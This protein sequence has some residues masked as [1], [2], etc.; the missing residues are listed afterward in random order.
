MKCPV[1][2]NAIPEQAPACLHCGFHLAKADRVFGSIPVLDPTLNDFAE[3]LSE[4]EKDRIIREV[5]KLEERF[6]QLRFAIV[7]TKLPKDAPLMAYYFWLFN[8]G[9]LVSQLESGAQ[10]RLVLL[11]LDVGQAR[12]FCMV[13]YGL[14]PFM[15]EAVLQ[16]VA[17]SAIPHLKAQE[18]AK[19]ALAALQE[20]DT[21]FA[22]VCETLPRAYG[23]LETDAENANWAGTL[24]VAY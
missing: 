23:L 22:A 7:L 9:N 6:P 17:S 21:Q 10:C 3:V 13:G 15:T 2:Q 4:K 20:I 8:R 14:E 5:E 12:A 11:G 24:D 18:P 16:T 19:A 1:C